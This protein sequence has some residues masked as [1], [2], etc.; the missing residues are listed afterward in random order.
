MNQTPE[1][2][3]LSWN[4]V[5]IYKDIEV[6]EAYDKERFS[7]LPGRIFDRLEKNAVLKA[8]SGVPKGAVIL[9][10]PCGTGRLAEVLLEAG[11]RVFGV[12]ISPAMLDVAT[13]IL[14]RFGD[15]FQAQVA[16]V[17]QLTLPDRHFDA[18]LCAR[19]LMHFPVRDQMSFLAAVSRLAANRVVFNQSVD[20]P[21][22]RARRVLKRVLRNQNP[23]AY[24]LSQDEL[25][26]LLQSA[27]LHE[28]RRHQ[29]FPLV[30]EA[31]VFST[32]KNP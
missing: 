28:L 11:Y 23:A 10:A 20:T 16:D 17:R 24:P 14:A 25:G 2:S 12:D 6:A 7:S 13:R 4:P 21:Y 19:I 22:N 5:E 8:F 18:A 1:P 3:R 27:S 26:Q 30:S 29:V 31:I 15:K 32:G 9:D